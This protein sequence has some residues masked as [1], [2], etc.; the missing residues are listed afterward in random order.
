MSP[1]SPALHIHC[2]HPWEEIV[3]PHQKELLHQPLHVPPFTQKEDLIL[4]P[5]NPPQ[6]MSLTLRI[7]TLH[8]PTHQ[9]AENPPLEDMLFSAWPTVLRLRLD[10]SLETHVAFHA[11]G[12]E[13]NCPKKAA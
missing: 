1:L 5:S 4:I 12:E 2:T 7:H 9:R 8:V 10:G 13:K 3:C 11:V 6:N